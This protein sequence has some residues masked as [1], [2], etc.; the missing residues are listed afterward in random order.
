MTIH[1]IH[2]L[3]DGKTL[4]YAQV[5][6]PENADDVVLVWVEAEE[7]AFAGIADW[8]SHDQEDAVREY[9]DKRVQSGE[10]VVLI[11]K[12]DLEQIPDFPR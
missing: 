9:A 10:S 1:T 12:D 2:R 11:R 8:L 7:V 5:K 4:T 6:M 3:S